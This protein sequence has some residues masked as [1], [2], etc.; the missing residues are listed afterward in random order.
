MKGV[1]RRTAIALVL[2]VAGCGGADVPK[3]RATA[4]PGQAEAAATATAVKTPRPKLRDATPCADLPDATCSTLR[5]PLDRSDPG[6]GSVNFRVAVAGKP[7]DPVVLMLSGGPGEA[8]RFLLKNGRRYLGRAADGV[9]L[10]AL[11]Q[12]G[13]GRDALRCPALQAVMG[14]SDLTPPPAKA[15]T[16][17]AAKLGD[18][19]RFYTTRE[20]V[21]DLEALRIALKAPELALD[22]TSYGTFVAQR[23]ALAHPERVSG[24]VLDSVVPSEGASL[25]SEVSMKATRRVMGDETAKQMAKVIAE[26][27]NGPAL[28]DILTALSVGDPNSTA[29][30]NA[31]KAAAEGNSGPLDGLIHGVRR[32]M[33]SWGAERLSQ[34]LHASTLC[35][36][37][38]APWGSAAAPVKGREQA[39]EHAA[40]R[41]GEADL[42]PYDRATATGNGFARQCL[43]WPPV[44][45]P[46]PAPAA[47]LPDVPTLLLAGDKD[48]S[49]P[50]EWARSALE[51][52]PGGK[53][54]VVKGAGHGVQSQGDERALRAVR[55]LVASL[56]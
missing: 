49:T 24:L 6:K 43:S 44:D 4:T 52:A 8:G 1:M 31:I 23:Y 35:A 12:R 5:V 45:V 54:I 40:S 48:L 26:H 7:G 18:D 47:E 3:P 36:D 11:D 19:R 16:A 22:G 29:A 32:V 39:L 2:V 37:T 38:P 21:E 50:M 14:A 30:A 51:H 34:G 53:L 9:R 17:C 33:R 56:R 25:L 13:T 10:V 41:L 28:L 46:P 20:T 55:E 15:V 27:H 42:Y